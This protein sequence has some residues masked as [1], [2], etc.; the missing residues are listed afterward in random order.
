[1]IQVTGDV[2]NTIV[3]EPWEY[4]LELQRLDFGFR[5]WFQGVLSRKDTYI[6]EVYISSSMQK[7]VVAIAHPIYSQ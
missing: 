6:S 3:L 1:M 7:P 4:Q 2:G 5:D